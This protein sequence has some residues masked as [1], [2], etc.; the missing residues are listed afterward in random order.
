MNQKHLGKGDN[1]LGNK[2][3]LNSTK[4]YKILFSFL[5]SLGVIIGGA[6]YLYKDFIIQEYVSGLVDD[7]SYY[8]NSYSSQRSISSYN[9]I[10]DELEKINELKYK[11]TFTPAQNAI[12]ASSYTMIGES[13][14]A[15]DFFKNSYHQYKN[16]KDM[17]NAVS[18]FGSFCFCEAFTDGDIEG[19]E[20]ESQQLIS[21][22]EPSNDFDYQSIIESSLKMCNAIKAAKANDIQQTKTYLSQYIRNYSSIW[23]GSIYTV[24]MLLSQENRNEKK[25]LEI[26]DSLKILYE[27]ENS[28]PQF[29]YN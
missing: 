29:Q 10:V 25:Y 18:L 1:V 27:Q 24:N 20:E 13:K 19:F 6:I 11:V 3:T 17:S 21:H 22:I 2:I 16:K 15:K 26:I 9:Q 4:G 28:N 5:L 23:H 8:S 14:K 7:L 12:I